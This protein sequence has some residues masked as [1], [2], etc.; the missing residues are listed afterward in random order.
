MCVN[1]TTLPKV[2]QSFPKIGRTSPKVGRS[3][4][5]IG[6]SFPEIGRSFPK[7]ILLINVNKGG[8][9]KHRVG[10]N[11]VYH[12]VYGANIGCVCC[13][14]LHFLLVLSVDKDSKCFCK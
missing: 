11:G 12:K 2:G 4:P 6:R 8:K 14:N 10:A 5:K 13:G 3:F 1:I 9:I 7:I